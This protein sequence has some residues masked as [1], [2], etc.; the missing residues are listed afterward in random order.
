MPSLQKFARTECNVL[1]ITANYTN[2]FCF[3]TLFTLTGGISDIIKYSVQVAIIGTK[4][5]Q[6]KSHSQ[7]AAAERQEVGGGAEVDGYS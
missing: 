5:Y 3:G 6:R 2:I 1:V 7:R 4:N